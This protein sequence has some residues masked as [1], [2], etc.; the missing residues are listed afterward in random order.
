[1]D[2]S[3]LDEILWAHLLDLPYFRAMLRAVEHSFYLE[4]PLERPTLD[5]GAGDG[6]FA[7]LVFEQPL[8]IGLDPWR[9]PLKEARA[10]QA[11]QLLIQAEGSRMP[12]PDASFG[13]IISNSV[14]EHIDDI[15]AVL[16][17][18]QRVLKLGGRF[19]F[20]VPNQRFLSDLWGQGVLQKLGLRKLSTQYNHFFNWVARHK[21]LDPPEVWTARL[22]RVGFE[23]ERTWH[24]FPKQAL[25][26]LEGGHLWGLHSLFWKKTIGRWVLIRKRWNPFIPYRKTRPFMDVGAIPEGVCTFYVARRRA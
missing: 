25:H 26:M 3:Q 6:H 13:S 15:D 2:A 23:V 21:H 10:R 5:L 4:L 12:Y 24:Y 7:S 18:V 9:A 20:C 22:E 14:L 8:E 11:Y 19:V 16:L 17:D 1:M